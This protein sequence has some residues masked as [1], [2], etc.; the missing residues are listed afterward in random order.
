MMDKNFTTKD[1]NV[2]PYDAIFDTSLGLKV[3]FLLI[4]VLAAICNILVFLAVIIYPHLRTAMNIYVVNLAISDLLVVC[5]ESPLIIIQVLF[6]SE[7][8][9]QFLTKE[10]CL[11]A[12]FVNT[13]A[14]ASSVMTL[15]A[16]SVERYIMV[17]YPFQARSLAHGAKTR[18]ISIISFG[19]SITFLMHLGQIFLYGS[20]E[21]FKY[22]TN[23]GSKEL[24]R[25]FCLSTLHDSEMPPWETHLYA[26]TVFLLI[27]GSAFT[28]T[29]VLYIKIILFLWKRKNLEFS[30]RT[31]SSDPSLGRKS[32]NRVSTIATQ[33]TIRIFTCSVVSYFCCYSVYFYVNFYYVYFGLLPNSGL[34]TVALAN[35]L[36][37][38]NSL[39]NP[40]LSTLFVDQFRK[41][42][43]RLVTFGCLCGFFGS[44][45]DTFANSHRWISETTTASRASME[46]SFSNEDLSRKRS[47]TLPSDS[48]QTT[49]QK[50]KGLE[51]FRNPSTLTI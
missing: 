17:V 16:L 42:I 24:S 39:V 5:F 48:S 36:G 19:W 4:I 49:H 40:I 23:D 12:Y 27:Y 46:S 45:D 29:L 44:A 25:T 15:L 41:A 21:K 34:F 2:D 31:S 33:N 3:A 18:V 32:S 28:I 9:E 14:G 51:D 35:L 7:I 22:V 8:S 50:R 6:E 13:F 10:C 26:A 20:T 37:A 43:L 47:E 30:G 1:I 38:I 11:V